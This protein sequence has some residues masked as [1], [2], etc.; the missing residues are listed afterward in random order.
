MTK[1]RGFTAPFF[2]GNVIGNSDV[3]NVDDEKGTRTQ[4]TSL[5]TEVVVKGG[6]DETFFSSKYGILYGKIRD[7]GGV[8]ASAEREFALSA[9]LSFEVER[10]MD[11]AID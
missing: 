1:H 11:G 10:R 6:P 9:N 4:L 2:T 5:I 8:S 3:K 7:W